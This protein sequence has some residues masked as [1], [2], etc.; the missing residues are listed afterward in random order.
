MQH[1][2]FLGSGATPPFPEGLDWLNVSRPLSLGE[3]RGRVV[4]LDFWTYG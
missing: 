3:L 1:I 4:V 2:P